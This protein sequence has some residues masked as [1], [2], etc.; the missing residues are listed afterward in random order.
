MVAI[1]ILLPLVKPFRA[2]WS[3][4]R[5]TCSSLLRTPGRIRQVWGP[6]TLRNTQFGTNC[7]R[8]PESPPSESVRAL[9][10]SPVRSTFARIKRIWPRCSNGFQEF[11]IMT[12]R[13]KINLNGLSETYSSESPRNLASR[14]SW[15]CTS[16]K[17]LPLWEPTKW[18][19]VEPCR[20]S[21]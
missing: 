20:F 2:S 5:F 8:L 4:N 13:E 14:P 6:R 15:R 3:G 11:Q 18:S 16:P 21:L 9:D 12:S 17:P 19:E 7:G 1:P 10:V